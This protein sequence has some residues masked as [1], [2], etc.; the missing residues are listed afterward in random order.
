MYFLFLNSINPIVKM[1]DML[2]DIFI[3]ANSKQILSNSAGWFI[4]LM[5][6]CLHNKDFIMNKLQ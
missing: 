5:R 1:N 4:H 6:D 2:C 3:A